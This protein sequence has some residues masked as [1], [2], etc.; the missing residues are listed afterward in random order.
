MKIEAIMHDLAELEKHVEVIQVN[1]YGKLG[2]I[3]NYT[4]TEEVCY[5]KCKIEFELFAH[6]MKDLRIELL[7]HRDQKL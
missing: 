2:L 1:I 7:K 6:R 4:P 5:K 3:T